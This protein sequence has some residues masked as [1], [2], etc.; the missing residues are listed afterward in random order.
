MSWQRPHGSGAFD[1][2]FACRAWGRRPTLRV[3]P[4]GKHSS[5]VAERG[6]ILIGV[7]ALNTAAPPST[8]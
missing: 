8:S 5:T 4:D 7:L 2:T 1:A 3:V 6:G